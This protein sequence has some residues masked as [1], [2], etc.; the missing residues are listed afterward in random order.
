MFNNA[1][2]PSISWL[3]IGTLILHS[4]LVFADVNQTENLGDSGPPVYCE[5]EL[6]GTP[7]IDDCKSAMQWIPFYEQVRINRLIPLRHLLPRRGPTAVWNSKPD[8]RHSPEV[9]RRTKPQLSAHLR[10]RNT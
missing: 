5:E 3:L 2:A 8:F 9:A 10:S 4:P 6:F 1:I 7:N